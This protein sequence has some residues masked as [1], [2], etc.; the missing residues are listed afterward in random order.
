MNNVGLS[1]REIGCQLG[2]NYTVISQ[3]LQKYQQTNDVKDRDHPGQPHKHLHEKTGHYFDL[4]NVT[5]FPAA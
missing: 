5:P 2:Q 4:L 1:Y 3:L